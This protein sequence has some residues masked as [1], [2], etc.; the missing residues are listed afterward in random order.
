MPFFRIFKAEI[1][2]NS[3]LNT[4][5][6]NSLVSLTQQ[7]FII[8]EKEVKLVGFWESHPAQNQ[9]KAEIK[10]IL[11]SREFMSLPGIMEKREE[12]ISRVIEL[13]QKQQN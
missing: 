4:E 7:I 13:A 1:F 6:I 10:K 9:L 3:D 8:I 5:Q 11:L 2:G 12:I